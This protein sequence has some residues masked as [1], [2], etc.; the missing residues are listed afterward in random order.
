MKV[1]VPLDGSEMSHEAML[2]GLGLIAPSK[3]EVTLLCVQAQGFDDVDDDRREIFEDDP[4]DEIFA[5]ASEAEEMLA[6]SAKECKDSV[7]LD[8]NTK[9]L[10]GNFVKL[11]VEEAESYDLVLM[12]HLSKEPLREKIR[13]SKAETLVRAIPCPV[14]LV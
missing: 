5:S 13:M 12:H 6:L 4:D 14:L 7:G 11:I 8:V 1:L 10:T 3:P 9:V 2:K